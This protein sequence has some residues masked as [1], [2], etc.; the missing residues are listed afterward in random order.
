MPKQTEQADNE[1]HE[2]QLLNF[3][4]NCLTR[5]LL[6]TLPTTLKSMVRISTRSSSALPPTGPRSPR[7]ARRV[8][9]PPRQTTF[10]ITYAQSLTS[11]LSNQPG[12]RFSSRISSKHFPS[13]RRSSL[14]STC[15]LTT[16]TKTRLTASTTA[17]PKQ[18]QLRSTLTPHSTH[19]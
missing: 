6:S 8:K 1:I 7:S 12:T 2:D 18:E 15:D 10:S 3:L 19:A 5:K 11:K 14:T 4:V 9:T 17:R 13:R 16:V